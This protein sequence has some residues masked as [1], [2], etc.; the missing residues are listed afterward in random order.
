[1]KLRAQGRDFVRKYLLKR[2]GE[3]YFPAGFLE[4]P[5]MGFGI[6]IAQWCA[7]PLAT[8]LRERLLDRRNPLFDL[9][10]FQTVREEVEAVVAA[11]GNAAKAWS[12]LM[13]DCWLE[14]VHAARSHEL[15]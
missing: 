4:R 3:T 9:I 10:D 14:A 13:L 11:N 8:I 15:A 1:M 2:A 6:P 7:G 5:K 12:F